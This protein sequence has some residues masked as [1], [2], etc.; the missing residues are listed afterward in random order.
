MGGSVVEVVVVGQSGMVVE[1][2]GT[3]VAGS[4]VDGMMVVVDALGS[5]GLPGHAV[6]DS[7]S[8]PGPFAMHFRR[9]EP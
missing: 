5:G 6:L 1:D 4:V 3:L 8:P 9:I 2:T 7:G